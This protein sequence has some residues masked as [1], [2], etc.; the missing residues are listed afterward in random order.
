MTAAEPPLWCNCGPVGSVMAERSILHVDMD[1][2]F[3]SVE[4]LRRPELRGQPVVVGGIGER[5]VVAAA[6]YEARHYGIHSAMP[7]V[8]AQRLCPHAV[9]L[10]G[11]HAHYNEVSSRVMTIFR[12]FTPL[13]E[14]ISLDEAFLDVTGARRLL[15]TPI[16]IAHAIRAEVIERE[17]LTCSVGVAPTKF[18]AKLASEAAKPRAG[19]DGPQPGL[20]VKVVEPDEVLRFLHPLPVQALWGV[21][22]K[23]LERLRSRGIN[24][25]G[26][27]AALPEPDA[28][29]HLGDANGRHLW[30]LAHGIDE[31][32]V[33]PDQR[34]KSIGHEET[35]AR[36]H[37]R[38]ETLRR[39]A[40]RMAD[41]VASKLR[42]HHLTGRT[43]TVKVRFHDFR[44]ITRSTTLPVAVAT[45]PAIARAVKSLLDQVDPT[46]GVRLLGVS[47]SGLV[48][49]GAQQLV[50]P[51]D[52]EPAGPVRSRDDEIA[53]SHAVE[54][55]RRRFG[56]A[57]IGP[58][59]AK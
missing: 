30:R 44:T 27:L 43:V 49:G 28:A 15:G 25:V 38:S 35:F 39:E 18:V 8:R 42:H 53:V 10:P 59:A 20:G 54:D 45:G 26:D 51:V 37:H 4:L 50:L 36:D 6:S 24:T 58:A 23:T 3:A 21:G 11:D 32:A 13:V 14:P 55:I 46:A 52:A 5:G 17:G 2:F 47:V 29:R 56:D 34:P 12:S 19:K 1:A 9:F 57:S 7:S 22:P 31:R 48:E 16:E 33:E 40:V 41:A